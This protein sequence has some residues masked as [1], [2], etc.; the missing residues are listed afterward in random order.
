[1]KNSQNIYIPETHKKYNV[2]PNHRKWNEEIFIW[3]ENLLRKIEKYTNMNNAYPYY[4]YKKYQN[5]FEEIDEWIKKYPEIKKDILNY[6]NSIIKLNNKDNWAIVQYIGVSNRDFTNNNFYYVV[7]YQEK[8]CWKVYGI[9]DNEEYNAFSVWS[10]KCTN[11][12]DLLKDFKII[13]DP[14]NILKNEF[15]KIMKEL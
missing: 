10:N 15:I 12:I 11:H 3:E 4:R 14:S 2:L 1:M 8:N 7:M 6:K 13:I 5:F 9:V